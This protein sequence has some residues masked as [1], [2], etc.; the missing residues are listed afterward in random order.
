MKIYQLITT[1][2]EKDQ[3]AEQTL[4]FPNFGVDKGCS[5]THSTNL[6]LLLVLFI[7]IL[8]MFTWN[9]QA[10]AILTMPE[11]PETQGQ[12]VERKADKTGEIGASEGGLQ[13]WW[14]CPWYL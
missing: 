13:N 5:R 4:S 12:I 1:E 7:E 8:N 11:N 9:R 10:N 2:G 6:R 3:K 14:K